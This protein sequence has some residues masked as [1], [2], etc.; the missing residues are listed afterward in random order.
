MIWFCFI[1]FLILYGT[2]IFLVPEKSIFSPIRFVSAK[3][4]FFNLPFI[5]F[6]AFYPDSFLKGILSICHTDVNSAFLKYTLA[7]TLAY[8]SLIAGV[9]LVRK[10]RQQGKPICVQYNYKRLAIYGCVIAILAFGAYFCFLKS[11]GGVAYLASNLDNRVLLQQGKYYL[12]LLELLPLLLLVVLLIFKRANRSVYKWL[13]FVLTL[14]C[15]LVLT[16][17]GGR[18][19]SLVLIGVVVV[20]WYY[21]VSPFKLSYKT[22]LVSGVALCAF[23]VYLLVIPQMRKV[24]GHARKTDSEGV[25]KASYGLV[26]QLSYVYIDV[27]VVNYFDKDKAWCMEG[28]FA[29]VKAFGHKGDKGDIPQVDQGVYLKSIFLKQKDFRPPLPRKDVSVTS[30]PTENF[31]FA[32]A[33][34]RWWGI[35]IFF[36]LQGAVFEVVY[37]FMMKNLYNPVLLLVYVNVILQFNFS[38]LRIA[39]FL[40]TF[41]LFSLCWFVFNKFAV[42]K[43]IK[44]SF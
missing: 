23:A 8:F 17:F 12:M 24:D 40:K 20:G 4:A 9:L 26:Y 13:F 38:S 29:P 33:N 30:W 21:Y 35:V 16:S 1:W 34:F 39:F 25:Y 37:S 19:P 36:F 28:Y 22:V 32:F 43:K 7:Q 5:L 14:I 3:F 6:T 11:I 10:R 27:L 18:K 2:G 44:S 31:G 41:L 15:V 42:E